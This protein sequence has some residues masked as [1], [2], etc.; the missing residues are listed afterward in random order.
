MLQE[1][2]D[3]LRTDD[4]ALQ[5]IILDSLRDSAGDPLNSGTRYEDL[6]VRQVPLSKYKLHMETDNTPAAFKSF[7]SRSEIFIDEEFSYDPHDRDLGYRATEHHLD[8]LMVLSSRIGFDAFLPNSPNDITFIFD[9]D[10]H[11]PHRALPMKHSD[12]G[13][14]VDHNA[15]FIGRSR[16]KD[17]IFLI[18]APNSFINEIDPTDDVADD[19]VPSAAQSRSQ[20]NMSGRH[21][22]ILVMYMAFVFHKHFP[23]R[24]IYCHERYPDLDLH[25]W[26]NV[27]NSTNLL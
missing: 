8:F 16:G 27:R 19:D 4:A 12:L 25:P 7:H 17:M 10:L 22:F 23:R 15:L 13:F 11:Q 1:V 21:Y 6:P 26:R 5:P 20:T 9:L 2:P 18:M 24:D 3:A 14:P